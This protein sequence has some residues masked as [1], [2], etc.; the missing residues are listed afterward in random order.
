MWATVAFFVSKSFKHKYLTDLI[1]NMIEICFGLDRSGC[2]S[3]TCSGSGCNIGCSSQPC[4]GHPRWAE[5]RCLPG[6]L[7]PA[8]RCGG[9][10][11]QGTY[12][13]QVWGRVGK[14]VK[15]EEEENE[16]EETNGASNSGHV[17]VH[18]ISKVKSVA[19]LTGTPG[20]ES[21]CFSEWKF[22]NYSQWQLANLMFDCLGLKP[23]LFCTHEKGQGML[24][25]LGQPVMEWYT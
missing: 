25:N 7:A 16:D 23:V 11:K 14:E 8:R 19:V 5:G 2:Y 4:R 9:A 3:P 12:L 15:S 1:F 22:T 21:I 17:I 6:W 13:S 24:R 20:Q 18:W 10:E